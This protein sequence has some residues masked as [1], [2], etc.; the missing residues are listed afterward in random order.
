MRHHKVD[1]QLHLM[2]TLKIGA[3]GLVPGLDQRV[4]S[5]LHQ[6]G[7]A[8]AEDALLAEQVCLGLLLEGGLKHAGAGA[9]DARRI[10]QRYILGV[11]GMVLIYRNKAGHPLALLVLASY[12]VPGALGGNHDDVDILGRD[13]LVVVNVKPVCKGKR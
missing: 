2:D 9:A 11:S 1:N 10:G 5:G 13:N 7:D 3:L 6:G 12:R 4:E 8:A